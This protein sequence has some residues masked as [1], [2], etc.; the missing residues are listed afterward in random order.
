MLNQNLFE[1]NETTRKTKL[2]KYETTFK[3][4]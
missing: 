1:E 4:S 2:T 3:V